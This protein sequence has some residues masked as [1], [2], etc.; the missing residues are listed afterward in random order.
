MSN[1]SLDDVG[2]AECKVIN[3]GTFVNGITPTLQL[4]KHYAEAFIF[5]ESGKSQ[6]LT[7]Q[8][9]FEFVESSKFVHM[10]LDKMLGETMNTI[11]TQHLINI[12]ISCFAYGLLIV[13]SL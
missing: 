9:L 8:L 2:Y 1:K 3:T 4:A 13:S 11:K 6:E 10:G 5:I 12:Y 7:Y